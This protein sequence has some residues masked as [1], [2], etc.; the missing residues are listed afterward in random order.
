[1]NS[2]LDVSGLMFQIKSDNQFL[3]RNPLHNIPRDLPPLQNSTI[4]PLLNSRGSVSAAIVDARGGGA[5]VLGQILY[6]FERL[7]LI[8]KIGHDRD[9]EAVR[10]E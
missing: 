9:P 10:G 3:N 6:V 4:K 1:M 5:R 2:G 8:K 7:V